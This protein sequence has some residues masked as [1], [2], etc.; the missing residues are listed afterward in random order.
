MIRR[1]NNHTARHAPCCADLV[2]YMASYAVF[3]FAVR[4]TRKRQPHIPETIST[5]RGC[6]PV[7]KASVV[8]LSKVTT[9]SCVAKA[10]ACAE[11]LF[12]T[13]WHALPCFGPG[14]SGK[15]QPLY[16]QSECVQVSKASVVALSKA[17]TASCGAK[18]AACAK[19]AVN[20]RQHPVPGISIQY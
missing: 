15:S 13:V 8:E 19:L 1:V 18:A 7:S 9:A 3:I 10:A 2:N 14:S 6:V 12:Q 17:T 5:K 20:T 11:L 16:E 4:P